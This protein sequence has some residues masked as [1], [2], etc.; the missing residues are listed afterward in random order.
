MASYITEEERVI[1]QRIM[2]GYHGPPLNWY[3]VLVSNLNEQDEIEAKL[4]PGISCPTVMLF[5]GQM[6]SVFPSDAAESMGIL[7]P[8]LF[9]CVST[10]GHWLQLEARD[11]VNAILKEFFEKYDN[12]AEC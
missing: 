7:G 3:I 2:E 6:K 4:C 10:P 8:S 5:P 11:E 12:T 9:K 1:H